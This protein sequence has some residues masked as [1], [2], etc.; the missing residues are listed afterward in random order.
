MHY[1]IHFE[2]LV[3]LLKIVVLGCLDR[4]EDINPLSTD[5]AYVV[6]VSVHNFSA[7]CLMSRQLY[8]L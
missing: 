6:W 7:L 8:T 2:F 3:T 4:I 5:F 1:F